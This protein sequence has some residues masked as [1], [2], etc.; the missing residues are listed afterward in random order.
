MCGII[1]YKGFKKC[2][3]IL[4]DGLK[5]LEYRGYD[6]AGVSY[7][8]GSQ[9]VT[10]KSVGCVQSLIDN[11]IDY[12]IESHIGIGHTRWATHGH[13]CIKNA[14]PH[15][16]LD[17]RLSLVHNGII[18]NYILLKKELSHKGYYFL[19][20]TDSEVLLYLIYDILLNSQCSLFNAVKW[21]LKRIIGAYAIAVLDAKDTNTMVVARRGSPLVVGSDKNKEFYV[22]S[23]ARVLADYT[24]SVMI[25]PDD[26]VAEI[27]D[28]VV[29]HDLK[30]DSEIVC[31]TLYLSKHDGYA[32]KGDFDHFMMKEIYEQPDVIV[33]CCRGRLDNYHIKLGGLEDFSDRFKGVDHITILACGSSYY[34]GLIGKYYFE[35]FCHIKTSV[36]YASEFIYRQPVLNKQ[37]M[38][39][40]ISQSGE[41]ADLLKAVELC[42]NRGAFV[43]GVCNVV[44]SSLVRLTDCGVFCRAGLEVGV[45]ST[46]GFVS[47]VVVLLMIAL[48]IDQNNGYKLI[49][50][51][52]LALI[53]GLRELPRIIRDTLKLNKK[54]RNLAAKYHTISRCLFI[55]REY[56]YPIA[57][58]GA[59]KLKEISYMNAEG[60]AAAEMK[61][62]PLALVDKDC[63]VIAISNN[64]KQYDKMQNSI[65]EV[66]ARNGVVVQVC[67][68]KSGHFCDIQVPSVIDP[69]SPIISVVVLQLFAYYCSVLKG[70]N[71]DKPR[72]L[73]KSVTVE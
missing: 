2:L 44:N 49:N 46:K 48:W 31:D 64:T 51:Y 63:L 52:R 32:D 65:K 24:N 33:D 10:F 55:G 11:Y 38:V 42:R 53:M 45:A 15:Y 21:A 72:N 20:D 26:S 17:G 18:E 67:D 16:T 69:L 54:I 70:Y 1:G 5:K 14:H 35:E 40:C 60:Y 37:D 27:S 30:D 39:L 71:V 6:S 62:G 28:K 58:E 9:L 7:V 43:V 12:D 19:S 34:A 59:L 25:L 56:N 57:L 8:V 47:Q 41:T 66:D 61:H 68:T 23:D 50:E 36:E 4:V 13:P 29:V 73:A 3:P 22:S